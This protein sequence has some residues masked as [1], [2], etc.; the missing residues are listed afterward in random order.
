VPAT[1]F[2]AKAKRAFGLGSTALAVMYISTA[3]PATA[4][5]GAVF[6]IAVAATPTRYAVAAAATTLFHFGPSLWLS[7]SLHLDLG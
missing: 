4:I 5:K 1:E 2:V 6:S 3:R 7:P